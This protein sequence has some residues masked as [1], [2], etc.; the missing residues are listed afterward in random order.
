MNQLRS[1]K[2]GIVANSK[3]IVGKKK[4]ADRSGIG[5]KITRIACSSST[6]GSKTSS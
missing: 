1:A 5:I 4:G 2:F 6:V 3:I